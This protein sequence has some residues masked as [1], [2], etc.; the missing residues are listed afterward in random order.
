[1]NTLLLDE[2]KVLRLD[3]PKRSSVEA[4]LTYENCQSKEKLA[5]KEITLES[6]RDHKD[7]VCCFRGLT[8][9]MTLAAISAFVSTHLPYKKR[10]ALFAFQA[11]VLIFMYRVNTPLRYI[12]Y[13]VLPT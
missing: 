8:V 9:F 10:R 7:T 6:L 12:A 2:E 4:R 11:L 1:M 5:S 13:T 3:L